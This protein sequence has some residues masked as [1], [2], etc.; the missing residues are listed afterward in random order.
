ME[1]SDKK[2]QRIDHLLEDLLRDYGFDH[3]ILEVKVFMK[4]KEAVGTLIARD[5]QP[6]SLVNGILTVNVS[7]NIW[8]TELLLRRHYVMQQIND[9]VGQP[10]VRELQFAIK[11]IDHP[12]R[13][14]IQR[15][16]RPQRLK[17]EKVALTSEVLEQINKTVSVVEDPDLKARLR[18]LFIK[19]SQRSVL[20]EKTNRD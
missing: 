1:K 13:L 11:P 6:V 17:L 10:A 9:A 7:H 19:Q 16:Q 15:F 3:K 2:T 18:R 14:K 12:S 8:M 20:K 5:T 4:W